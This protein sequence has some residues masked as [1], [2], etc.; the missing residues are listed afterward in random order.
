M[1]ALTNLQPLSNDTAY[2]LAAPDATSVVEHS[3]GYGGTPTSQKCYATELAG[4]SGYL[5][6]DFQEV[7]A[8]TEVIFTDIS[9]DF[10]R[11]M[12]QFECFKSANA[13]PVVLEF[14]TNNGSSWLGASYRA[15]TTYNIPGSAAVSVQNSTTES[16]V[17]IG[18]AQ[19]TGENQMSG[20]LSIGIGNIAVGNST[21]FTCDGRVTVHRNGT[22]AGTLTIMGLRIL[23]S[24]A[25]GVVDAIRISTAGGTIT[26]RFH[27]IGVTEGF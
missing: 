2:P 22:D 8:V 6:H 10:V 17:V 11:C 1:T 26:G 15:Q 14:S 12:L 21:M 4:M 18:V 7:S 25:T 16:N 3:K 27:L 23:G 20:V 5:S 19:T 24:S 9:S 13:S